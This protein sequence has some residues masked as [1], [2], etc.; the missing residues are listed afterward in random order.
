MQQSS[1][2]FRDI[3]DGRRNITNQHLERFGR[4]LDLMMMSFLLGHGHFGPIQD[5]DER[6]RAYERIAAAQRMHSARLLKVRAAIHPS[7]GVSCHSRVG[8]AP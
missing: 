3:I 8:T 4:S 1:P 6:R 2:V 7:M 5:D